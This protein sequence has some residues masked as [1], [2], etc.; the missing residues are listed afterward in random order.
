M[1]IRGLS[2]WKDGYVPPE[3]AEFQDVLD[4]IGDTL[5]S[6]LASVIREKAKNDDIMYDGLVYSMCGKT[7]WKS[8]LEVAERLMAHRG[9]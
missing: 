8:L 1:S 2:R 9:S 5:I 6:K 7:E 3:W 4:E